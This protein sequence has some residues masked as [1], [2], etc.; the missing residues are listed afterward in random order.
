MTSVQRETRWEILL[1]AGLVALSAAL[2]GVHYRLFGDAHHI[3]LYLVGDLAFLPIQVLLVTMI[4]N[5][6]M[7]RRA[8][9]AVLDKLN[10]VI[11]AFFSQVGQPL[12][13]RICRYDAQAAEMAGEL[14]VR[15]TWDAREFARRGARM[16][17]RTGDV[18][19]R[20]GGLEELR[21][22]LAGHR[23]FLLGL[24]ENPNLLEHQAFTELMWAVFHLS[25]EL[26]ARPRLD[27]LPETDYAHLSGDIR[28]VENLLI[29]EWLMYL[30]HQQRE[31]PYLFSLAV[32][33]NPFDAGASVVVQ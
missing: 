15:Q 13:T 12:L 8:K 28:R 25:E 19:S 21:D 3:F 30:G 4:L 20:R 27:G 16:R 1:A 23:G 17:T 26:A 31:Y 33:T 29:A 2:Y 9:R 7:A 6:L 11:G 24:L 22:F 14:L 10:M 18:D 32:R 5:R